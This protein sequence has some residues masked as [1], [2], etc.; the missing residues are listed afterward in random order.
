MPPD[1]GD[2]DGSVEKVVTYPTI[3]VS[4]RKYLNAEDIKAMKEF[5]NTESSI[6]FVI[7]LLN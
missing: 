7:M 2:A 1:S 3:L 4:T 6:F 5:V